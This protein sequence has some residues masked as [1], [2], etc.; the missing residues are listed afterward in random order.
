[1]KAKA[2]DEGGD[3]D[4]SLGKKNS[5]RKKKVDTIDDML[6]DIPLNK[7]GTI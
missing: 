4:L 1:M 3:V 6:A 7:R 2:G 5:G